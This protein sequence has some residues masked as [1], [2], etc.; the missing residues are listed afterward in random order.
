MPTMNWTPGRQSRMGNF[1]GPVGADLGARRRGIAG[2]LTRRQRFGGGMGRSEW[3]AAGGAVG[4]GARTSSYLGRFAHG[5]RG[6]NMPFSLGLNAALTA[7]VLL[8]D[9]ITKS[10]EWGTRTG[11]Q[12]DYVGGFKYGFEQGKSKLI[13]SVVGETIGTVIGGAIGAA[14]PIPGA[15]PFLAMAGG[16]VGA[17]FGG[18]AFASFNQRADYEKGRFA[19]YATAGVL[20]KRKVQFGRGFRDSEE[21]YTMRQMAVQEMAGSLLNARQY[22]GNEAF[23]FHR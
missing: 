10:A 22:L 15:A 6:A 19:S 13:G 9:P 21:A 14:I 2:G 4:G 7:P 8:T 3:L 18:D 23:F 5:I 1:G 16:M 11:F 17:T 20:A 12:E